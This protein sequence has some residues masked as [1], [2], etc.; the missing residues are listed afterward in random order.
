MN[1]SNP[2]YTNLNRIEQ[3]DKWALYVSM[4]TKTKRIYL[5][6]TNGVQCDVL[7][8]EKL[9]KEYIVSTLDGNHYKC[10]TITFDLVCLDAELYYNILY[11]YRSVNAVNYYRK[12]LNRNRVYTPR[13]FETLKTKQ[14]RA[15]IQVIQTRK[16]VLRMEKTFIF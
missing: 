15:T 3:F 7:E 4:D 10:R 9:N 6:L 13:D 1:R 14:R 12:K 8:L 16:K 5:T 2:E 11:Y